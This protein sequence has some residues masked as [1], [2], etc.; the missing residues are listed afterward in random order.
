MK[1]HIKKFI[2]LC[3]VLTLCLGCL[4]GCKDIESEVDAEFSKYIADENIAVVHVFED[5]LFNTHNLNLDEIEADKKYDYKDRGLVFHQKQIYFTR[6]AKRDNNNYPCIYKCDVYGNNVEKVI[7]LEDV[8][9]IASSGFEKTLYLEFNS[10]KD[11]KNSV[12]KS[13]NVETG[14]YK[15]DLTGMD[16][17]SYVL[18]LEKTDKQTY[19]QNLGVDI[20]ID[21]KNNCFN[22]QKRDLTVSINNE[23][24]Q[25][26]DFGRS[27]I[28][29][30]GEV[31]FNQ[32]I[33]S[34]FYLGYKVNY[35]AAAN[36]IIVLEY[37]ADNEEL[38]YKGYFKPVDVARYI[39]TIN[40]IRQIY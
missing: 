30:D 28:K 32:S 26:Y 1:K 5:V 6:T 13:Y 33:E 16:V 10:T 17:D 18:V 7:E 15:Y 9:Y 11:R 34:G 29:Y 27:L 19:L 3:F 12:I 4:T 40:S 21:S 37:K 24:L 36:S 35:A 8:N 38:I 39:N 25:D 14:E 23:K 31:L 20:V 2:C 22:I